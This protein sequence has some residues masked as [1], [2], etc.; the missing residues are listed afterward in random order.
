MKY[1]FIIFI[2]LVLTLTHGFK[3]SNIDDDKYS[4]KLSNLTDENV[5]YCFREHENDQL[6]VREILGKWKVS[7][8]YMHLTNEG[9]KAFPSCPDVTIWETADFP[10]TTFGVGSYTSILI[11]I[12][13]T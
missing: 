10:T 4:Y 13:I 3:K 12:Y 7:E 9:V 8:V 1:Q 5:T 6:D 2:T 11:L